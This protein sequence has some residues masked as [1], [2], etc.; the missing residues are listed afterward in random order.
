MHHKLSLPALIIALLLPHAAMAEEVCPEGTVGFVNIET[1]QL[2]CLPSAQLENQVA[3]DTMVESDDSDNL[4][5]QSD[6]QPE[7][8]ANDAVEDAAQETATPAPLADNNNDAVSM[9]ITPK[10]RSEII[11][12]SLMQSG[13]QFD[14]GLG[15]G[16]IA[17]VNFKLSLGYQF[18]MNSSLSTFGLYLI[19][20]FKTGDEPLFD[21]DITLTPTLHIS[22][23]IFRFSVGLGLGLS[24]W[25]HELNDDWPLSHINDDYGL[26]KDYG[27]MFRPVISF[28]WFLS[29]KAF[30]GF[31]V[32][33]PV[34]FV[35]YCDENKNDH[36]S[37]E[38]IPMV[39][40]DLHIGYKF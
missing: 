25:N 5:I 3:S 15:Y 20:N 26:E 16:M 22:K 39:N 19:S 29:Q 4:E 27:F 24:A 30:W 32:D 6:Q 40:F 9:P 11:H 13:F 23:G 8:D 38:T 31:T 28:D 37:V 36:G 7:I 33:I 10:S 12:D 2:V 18:S 17:D 14:L 34:V 21:V 1:S 35:E